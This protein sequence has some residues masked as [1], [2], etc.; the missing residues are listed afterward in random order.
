M[1]LSYFFAWRHES[2]RTKL[3]RNLNLF[4]SFLTVWGFCTL[5]FYVGNDY[6]VY[7]NFYDLVRLGNSTEIE[8]FFALLYQLTTNLPG[9]FLWM[10]GITSLL[11]YGS[12]FTYFVKHRILKYGIVFLF[13][14]RF[15]IFSNDVIRQALAIAIL[16]HSIDALLGRK[17]IRYIILSAFMLIIHRSS[18][19]I[20]LTLPIL[21]QIAFPG[22]KGWIC[23]LLFAYFTGLTGILIP[24]LNSLIATIPHYG[25]RYAAAIPVYTFKPTIGLLSLYMLFLGIFTSLHL[26]KANNTLI[27][28]LFLLGIT[29]SFLFQGLFLFQRITDYFALL[30]FVP[31]AH[32]AY[33]LS[34]ARI[35][36][37]ALLCPMLIYFLL[38]SLYAKEKH[39]A[40]PYQT[41]IGYSID[42]IE[43]SRIW[44]PIDNESKGGST[45]SEEEL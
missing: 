28:H 43:T 41:W 10:F 12:I 40:V 20:T 7:V 19:L 25:E 35:T 45:T 29:L 1:L 26:R 5:R 33:A 22:P 4:L 44:F 6:V 9:S 11:T 34:T 36:R 30:G 24:P 31:L 39:G 8:P 27:T 32:I 38:Q 15:L 37:L 18:L 21:R 42:E 16:L 3:G 17:W 23:L 2:S 14:T 13:L